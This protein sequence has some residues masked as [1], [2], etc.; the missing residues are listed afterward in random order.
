M[1]FGQID[2]SFSILF[3]ELRPQRPASKTSKDIRNGS[4]VSLRLKKNYSLTE[5]EEREIITGKQDKKPKTIE[6]ENRTSTSERKKGSSTLRDGPLSD[7]ES[8]ETGQ[9]SDGM[10]RAKERT[11]KDSRTESISPSSFQFQP[12]P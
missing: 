12:D 3:R 7:T 1:G 5:K 4:E 11:R 9:L 10:R 6:R 2:R 8:K